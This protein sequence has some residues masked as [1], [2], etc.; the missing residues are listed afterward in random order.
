MEFK[1]FLTIQLLW[2]GILT[3]N[4]CLKFGE[5]S[6]A[7]VCLLAP[8]S[9]YDIILGRDSVASNVVSMNCETN[10]WNLQC[11]SGKVVE[12][13][14][15]LLS[16]CRMVTHKLAAMSNEDEVF[17]SRLIRRHEFYEGARGSFI[18]LME[19][20]G[21]AGPRVELPAGLNTASPFKKGCSGWCLALQ[22]VFEPIAKSQISRGLLCTYVVQTDDTQR[23]HQPARQLSP[24]SLKTLKGHLAG[25]QEACFIHP[26]TPAWSL[27]I[28]M[29]SEFAFASGPAS[30]GFQRTI[31]PSGGSDQAAVSS[32]AANPGGSFQAAER[33]AA[34]ILLMPE[35][36]TKFTEETDALDFSARVVF[37]Q[38]DD[39]EIHTYLLSSCRLRWIE[40]LAEMDIEVRHKKGVD[41]VVPD[42]LSRRRELAS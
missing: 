17:L 9:G 32:V 13:H 26:S 23:V 11:H 22:K 7:V 40:E 2:S 33:S 41:D 18:C 36:L 16:Q 6:F 29:R 10:T 25:L 21:V 5:V 8:L 31:V 39:E 4:V 12:F 38:D 30:D 42:A 37:L 24:T 14:L 28:V 35:V 3:A 20:E 34:P 19:S 1:I 15:A 27:P